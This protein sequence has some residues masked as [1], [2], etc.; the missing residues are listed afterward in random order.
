MRAAVTGCVQLA[1]ERV[2][3]GL[4]EEVEDYAE[5]IASG[6]TPSGE[7]RRRVEQASPL[8]VLEEEAHA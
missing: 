2:P 6:R 4:R 7:L 8:A 5:L 1:A 3:A